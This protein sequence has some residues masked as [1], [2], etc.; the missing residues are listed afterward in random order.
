MCIKRG[1]QGYSSDHY[2]LIKLLRYAV[3]NKFDDTGEEVNDL[4]DTLRN[5]TGYGFSYLEACEFK[6]FDINI[7]CYKNGKCVI[8]GLSEEQRARTVEGFALYNK[9]SGRY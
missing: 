3:L 6:V 8:K 5:T 1:V 2:P 9:Y 4:T 7:R